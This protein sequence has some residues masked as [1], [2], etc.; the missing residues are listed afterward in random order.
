MRQALADGV[1][2]GAVLLVGRGENVLFH[3]AYGSA[4]RFIGEP[5]TPGNRLRSRL[6]HQTARDNARRHAASSTGPVGR[7]A[8]AGVGAAGV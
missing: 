6:P 2:P 1:F 5:M 3:A 4:N 7:G 8:A